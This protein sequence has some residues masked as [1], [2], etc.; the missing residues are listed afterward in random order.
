MATVMDIE[1]PTDLLTYLR[2]QG[3]ID[4]TETP[5]CQT[6]SGGVSNRTVRVDR[7]NGEAWVIKQALEKLRVPVDWFSSP[8]RIHRE[9]EG[10]RWLNKLA[11]Q[12]SVPEFV[13]EDHEHHL[14]AMQAIPDPH[15]NWKVA[16]LDGRLDLTQVRQFGHLLGQIQRQAEQQKDTI[17]AAFADRTFFESLRLEPYYGYT[18]SQVPQA[19]R[20]L[21]QLINETRACRFT[22]VHGDYSPKNTL[23]YQNR[24]ILLDYEVIHFGDP[25]FDLGFSLTHFLSKAHHLPHLRAE[26][27]QASQI[28]WEAYR[29]TLGNISWADDLEEKAVHHT[30]ACLLAR[31]AGRSPLE[32]LSQEAR[33]RQQQ[34]VLTLMSR[35]PATVSSLV[36]QFV[37]LIETD[38]S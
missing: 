5:Q 27:M 34:A 9:A 28:Y 4:N 33:Q 2:Q 3:R 18:A 14:L 1:N 35:T 8:L 38:S 7:E 36:E 25:A 31:V 32:Y 37:T 23:V 12:Q 30:L 29:A 16:L 19:T 13:F 26:F 10:L 24:L 15:E 6:L 20:F 17:A 22:L 21:N 11:P